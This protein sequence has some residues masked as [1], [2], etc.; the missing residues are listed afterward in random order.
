MS[1]F[2]KV[3]SMSTGAK[4]LVVAVCLWVM[5]NYSLEKQQ[6]NQSTSPPEETQRPSPPI[7]DGVKPWRQGNVQAPALLQST[8][9]AAVPFSSPTALFSPRATQ[10]AVATVRRAFPALSLSPNYLTPS[11][12]SN[13]TPSPEPIPQPTP[14]STPNLVRIDWPDGRIIQHPER[15]V[16]TSV[17][18]VARGD[19]LKLRSGPGTKFRPITEIPADATDIVAFDKDA[20]WDG[21]TWWYPIEWRGFRG[22]VGGRYLP[23]D[24]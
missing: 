24:R 4:L 2:A 10:S 20:V 22:Y 14:I 5:L 8:P 1:I 12:D 17:V 9:S 21:D 7:L 15:A 3:D 18:N 23:H 19:T 16:P 13:A 11:L 6:G